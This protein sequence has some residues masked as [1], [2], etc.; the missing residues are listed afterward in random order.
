MS[1]I[2]Y[3]NYQVRCIYAPDSD[4]W[5]DTYTTIFYKKYYKKL[6]R[7]FYCAYLPIFSTNFDVFKS[8]LN[9]NS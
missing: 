6:G 8:I 1:V 2:L 5:R 7:Q 3:C 9:I 4:D